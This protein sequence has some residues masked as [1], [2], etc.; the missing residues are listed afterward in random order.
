M[1]RLNPEML[2]PGHKRDLSEKIKEYFKDEEN[3]AAIERPQGL[4]TLGI[5]DEAHHGYRI[6]VDPETLTC[7]LARDRA[8]TLG[9]GDTPFLEGENMQDMLYKVAT[10]QEGLLVV[11][12]SLPLTSLAE[13]FRY[14][15]REHLGTGLIAD[16]MLAG[17]LGEIRDTNSYTFVLVPQVSDGEQIS[18]QIVSVFNDSFLRY[19]LPENELYHMSYEEAIQKVFKTYAAQEIAKDRRRNPKDPSYFPT[20]SY[21]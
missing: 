18:L 21:H 3:R 14:A 1:L 13:D 9:S 10:E 11:E 2:R 6:L 7:V 5:I 16:P 8:H 17:T 20:R 12:G 19:K 15:Y 4:T